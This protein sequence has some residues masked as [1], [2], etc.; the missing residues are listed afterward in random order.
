SKGLA[1][2]GTDRVPAAIE[3]AKA[4]AAER[5]SKATFQVAD[6]LHLSALGRTFDTVLDS[7]LF[8]VF[9]D[10][11][12]A[13]YVKGLAAVV[14]N[15]GSLH[16]LCFSDQEPSPEGPRRIGERELVELFNMRGWLVEEIAEARSEP[17]LHPAGARACAA[18]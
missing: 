17:T 10:E 8:H 5:G 14:K 18:T 6:A 3:K 16:I 11:D 4:R 1:V 15:R 13:A 12:R 7:G 9:S 2:L